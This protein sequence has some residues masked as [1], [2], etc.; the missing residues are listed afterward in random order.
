MNSTMQK[1]PALNEYNSAVQHPQTAFSDS[2]LKVGKVETTGLGL[3]RALG[4]GF[5]ITY[6]IAAGS[7]KYAVRC[8]HKA[9]PDLEQKYRNIGSALVTDNSGY[10][11]G[12]K[13]EPTGVLV[14]GTRFPIVKMDW[15]E[16]KTLDAWLES[17]VNN[18]SGLTQLR[19]QFQNLETYLRGKSYA[20]GD[21]Q[22]GNVIV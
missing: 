16:G 15:A 20:H 21:L 14:N 9:A 5:A 6:T 12:F 11:V 8:F 17:N 18:R 13:Y 10:F 22:N 7:K 2:D 3:P 4:G 1:Y 19:Q